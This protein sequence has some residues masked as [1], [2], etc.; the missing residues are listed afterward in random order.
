MQGIAEQVALE[1]LDRLGKAQ[2]LAGAGA[3]LLEGWQAQGV[4]FGNVTQFT[5]VARPVVSHQA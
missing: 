3:G 5:H 1:G 2:A 4:A